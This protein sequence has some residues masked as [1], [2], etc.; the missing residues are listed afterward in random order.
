MFKLIQQIFTNKCPNCGKGKVFKDKNIV[1]SMSVPKMNSKCPTCDYKY[2][3]EPGF[4]IGAMYVSYGLGVAEG[5]ITYF[6]ASPFFEKSLD[7]KII[8]IIIGI[9]LLLTF[10]NIRISRMIWLYMFRSIK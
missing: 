2:I 1:F 6:F 4:F 9:M 5:L 8:P 3:K 7:M 10:F